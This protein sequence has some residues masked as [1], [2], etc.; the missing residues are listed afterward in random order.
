VSKLLA[1]MMVDGAIAREGR[2]Y[3]L[4]DT[5]SAS[6]DARRIGVVRPITSARGR[7]TG[8]LRGDAVG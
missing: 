8:L 5:Q 3:I 2:H 6:S 7:R 4:L 1:E